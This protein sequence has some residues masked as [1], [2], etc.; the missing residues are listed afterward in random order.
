MSISLETY[1]FAKRHAEDFLVY[2]AAKR[3]AEDFLVCQEAKR[4]AE[5]F[6]VYQAA[7]RDAEDFL[8]CQAAKRH[9]KK[10]STEFLTNCEILLAAKNGIDIELERELKKV[11]FKH[12]FEISEFAY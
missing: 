9:A 8:V 4:D 2:Q 12:L 5:D 10:E 11:C 1:I 3:D 6:L 7:K